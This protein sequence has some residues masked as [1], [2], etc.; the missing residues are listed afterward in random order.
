MFCKKQNHSG[1][2]DFGF[3][4]VT[5]QDGV[6]VEFNASGLDGK[7]PFTG[8]AFHIRGFSPDLVRFIWDIATAGDMVIFNCQGDDSPES[9][10]LILGDSAQKDHVPEM[11]YQN[12]PVCT[13]AE[14]LAK[15]L[16]VG[17]KSW[18]DYRDKVVEASS[19]GAD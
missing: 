17:F 19:K 5:F 14:M 13:S 12:C 15:L 3:Y 10:V 11:G 16:G 2:D 6:N 4:L 8:C 9:P 7:E 1:P 18:S